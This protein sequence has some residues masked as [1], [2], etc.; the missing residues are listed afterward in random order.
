M[1]YWLVKNILPV[2]LNER[3]M[4][5]EKSQLIFV[6]ILRFLDLLT[7]PTFIGLA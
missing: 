2:I 5:V 6:L 1:N 4:S 7:F 3:G